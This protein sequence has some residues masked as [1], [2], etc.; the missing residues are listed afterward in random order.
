M[1]HQFGMYVIRLQFKVLE[2][3]ITLLMVPQQLLRACVNIVN[4][5]VGITLILEGFKLALVLSIEHCAIFSLRLMNH[6]CS[7][8]TYAQ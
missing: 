6:Y 2:T 8:Y 3:V 1:L 7:V 5:Y 4:N